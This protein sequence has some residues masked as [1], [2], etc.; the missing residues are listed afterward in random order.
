LDQKGLDFCKTVVEG[1]IE[2]LQQLLVVV[3]SHMDN[4]GGSANEGD[5]SKNSKQ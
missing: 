3:E 2:E 5:Q 1:H 4:G